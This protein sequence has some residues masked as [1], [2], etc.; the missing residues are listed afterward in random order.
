MSEQSSGSSSPASSTEATTES[1]TDLIAKANMAQTWT[2]LAKKSKESAEATKETAKDI[3]STLDALDMHTF[4]TNQFKRK[5]QSSIT[6]TAYPKPANCDDL[7]STMTNLTNAVDYSGSDYD[8][9]NAMDIVTVLASLDP[10]TLSPG[11]LFKDLSILN[12]SRDAANA[13]AEDIVTTQTNLISAKNN[14]LNALV[15][16]I[17]ALNRQISAA[18][19]TTINPGTPAPTV[20]SEGEESAT[21]IDPVPFQGEESTIF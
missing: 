2:I 4:I 3:S 12:A 18:G 19:G 5:D 20:A 1:L 10:K 14:E 9:A 11:C 13:K 6:T 16:L 7:K 15:F 21:T 8:L 17:V